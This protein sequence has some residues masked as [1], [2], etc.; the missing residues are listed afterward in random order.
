VL[1]VTRVSDS[2]KQRY[3]KKLTSTS[4]LP[5]LLLLLLLLVGVVLLVMRCSASSGVSQ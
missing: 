4:P 1:L 5:P 2:R 3:S